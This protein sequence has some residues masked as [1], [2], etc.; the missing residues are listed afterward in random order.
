M[1]NDEL[2]IL[3]TP[4]APTRNWKNLYALLSQT[5]YTLVS[6]SLSLFFSLSLSVPLSPAP[7]KDEVGTLWVRSHGCLPSYVSLLGSTGKCRCVPKMVYNSKLENP[8]GDSRAVSIFRIYVRMHEIS[9]TSNINV[10]RAVP[11]K[12]YYPRRSGCNMQGKRWCI[13]IADLSN[14]WIFM[15]EWYA[16]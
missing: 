9:P 2:I 10:T 7:A 6:L 16:W 3:S 14:L 4:V 13:S 15:R 1:K 5:L 12:F 11:K 8:I